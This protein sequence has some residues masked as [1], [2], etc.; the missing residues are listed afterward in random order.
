MVAKITWLLC[1]GI[2]GRCV[3]GVPR[4]TSLE[5]GSLQAV[6]QMQ[7]TASNSHLAGAFLLFFVMLH[8]HRWSNQLMGRTEGRF[9]LQDPHQVVVDHTG[10]CEFPT[11]SSDT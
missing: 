8:H 9:D 5:V 2:S 3:A 7:I 11:Q 4:G 10:Y 6:I 1:T